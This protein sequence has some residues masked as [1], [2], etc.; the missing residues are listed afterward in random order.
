M[1]HC[2]DTNYI[3]LTLFYF[4]IDISYHAA[5]VSSNWS[6]NAEDLKIN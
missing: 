5:V 2:F 6:R 1:Y 4:F 3:L